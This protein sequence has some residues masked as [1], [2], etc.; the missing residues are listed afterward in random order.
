VHKYIYI[1]C[2]SKI[3]IWMNW[4]SSPASN[5]GHCGIVFHVVTARREVETWFVHIHIY[6][7][8]IP[9]PSILSYSCISVDT[10]YSANVYKMLLYHHIWWRNTSLQPYINHHFSGN[11]L[12]KNWEFYDVFPWVSH[13]VIILVPWW[14]IC[15]K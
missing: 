5:F 2:I 9:N 10:E 4:N 13:R 12:W 8:R 15:R 14:H 3:Y 7:Y 6:I 11:I 1:R